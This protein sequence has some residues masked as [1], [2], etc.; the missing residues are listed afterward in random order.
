MRFCRFNVRAKA[1]R[2]IYK[3]VN[4]TREKHERRFVILLKIE[5]I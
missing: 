1:S 2:V 4:Y 5:E 3:L